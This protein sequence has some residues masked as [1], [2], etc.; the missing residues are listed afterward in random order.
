MKVL[1]GLSGGVD[2]AVAAY[3][4]KEQGYEVVGGFM[5]NYSSE[6]SICTTY[7]DAEEAIKV[8]DFL[9]IKLISFDFQAEYQDRIIN[10]IYEGYQRGVTPNPDVLCNSLIKFDLFL[11]QALKL[12]FDKI[13][14]GHYARVLP[15]NFK[16]WS[17]SREDWLY[18]LLRGRDHHKDQSYF[19]AGL[20]QFQLQHAMFPLWELDKAAVRDLAQKIWL[21]NADRKD[22]QGL[23]FIWNIPIK[24]FLQQQLPIKKWP[25]KTLEGKIVGEHEGAYF[26]TIGQK[27]GLGL[28]FKAYVYR[29]DVKEN[30]VYVSEREAEELYSDELMLKD[31]H[32]IWKSY[33]NDAPLT[34][35]IRYRQNPPVACS[36]IDSEGDQM[37]ISFLERQWAVAPGQT[38]VLYDGEICLWS[39]IIV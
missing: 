27:H 1:I 15:P 20:S 23:C 4:L 38:F 36:I 28:N 24:T 30:I 37:K 13:A 25:I 31:W 7:Q 3:L 33:S 6:D 32:W 19:L 14:T 9:W 11:E 34:G 16:S 39:G 22:S 5:R 21:P 17:L 26:F 29:I 12:G 18:Q 35:K 8:A 10:Y 2:S